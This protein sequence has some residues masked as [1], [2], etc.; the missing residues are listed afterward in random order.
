MGQQTGMKI[1][2]VGGPRD[3]HETIVPLGLVD[4][5]LPDSEEPFAEF[6]SCVVIDRPK[7][8]VYRARLAGGDLVHVDG[9]V[10]FDYC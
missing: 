4:L 2:C 6:R 7:Y 1:R 9:V 3:G 8:H 5:T 10:L